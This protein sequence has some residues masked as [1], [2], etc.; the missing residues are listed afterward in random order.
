MAY[1]IDWCVSIFDY[2][3]EGSEVS[4][5]SDTSFCMLA[6]EFKEIT[7]GGVEDVCAR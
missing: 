2:N 1:S 3:T 4:V 6:V 7:A 5:L